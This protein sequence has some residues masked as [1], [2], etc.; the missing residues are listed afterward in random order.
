MQFYE[1]LNLKITVSVAEVIKLF[2]SS[3]DEYV[4]VRI[5]EKDDIVF[6]DRMTSSKLM[7]YYTRKVKSVSLTKIPESYSEEPYER[8]E[9]ITIEVE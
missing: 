9:G 7:P 5:K 8:I 4:Y 3:H 2:L 6:D 1:L